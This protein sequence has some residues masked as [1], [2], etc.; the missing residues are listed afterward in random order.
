MAITA[1]C[2][3]RDKKRQPGRLS[4]MRP[5]AAVQTILALLVA[6][7]PSGL[8]LGLGVI[9]AFIA[10]LGPPALRQALILDGGFSEYPRAPN[11]RP[12]KIIAPCRK[13]ALE[14]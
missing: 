3:R 2:A 13:T 4:L 12:T 5:A 14:V 9:P 7:G 1:I 6:L 11:L 8:R 10:R